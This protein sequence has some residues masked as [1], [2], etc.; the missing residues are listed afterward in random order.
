MRL[1]KA[2][3]ILM[4]LPSAICAQ[5]FGETVIRLGRVRPGIHLQGPRLPGV[6]MGFEFGT[7]FCLD[8]ECRFVATNYHIAEL[9]KPRKIEGERIVQTYLATGPYDRAA[10][11]K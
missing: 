8:R 3:F 4:L 11:P 9:V 2:I 1:F 5:D 7:G 10:T 6:A